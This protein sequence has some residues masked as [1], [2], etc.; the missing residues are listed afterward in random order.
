MKEENGM[1]VNPLAPKSPSYLDDFWDLRPQQS[2]K[3]SIL[4]RKKRKQLSS[5]VPPKD[6]ERP[7]V[8]KDVEARKPFRDSFVGSLVSTLQPRVQASKSNALAQP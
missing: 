4:P 3:K 2:Q 8:V 5:S 6:D 7:D 1:L